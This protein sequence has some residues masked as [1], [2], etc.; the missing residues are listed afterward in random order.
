MVARAFL[1]S[2]LLTLALAGHPT[3][4]TADAS[5]TTA[6]TVATTPVSTLN[7][8]IPADRPIGDCISALP[9][10]GC[11]SEARADW[12]QGAVAIGLVLAL[13]FIAWRIVAN[14]RRTPT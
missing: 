7:E 12:R 6:T 3:A 13:C 10:P 4:A 11:G 5:V 1:L 2:L 9:K 8:F 14:L